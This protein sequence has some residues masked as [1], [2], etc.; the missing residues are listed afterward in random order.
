MTPLRGALLIVV[1]A[2]SSCAFVQRIDKQ[3][4]T[5]A[6]GASCECRNMDTGRF[7]KCP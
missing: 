5:T 7:I 6:S 2:L 4:T 3:C 1:L